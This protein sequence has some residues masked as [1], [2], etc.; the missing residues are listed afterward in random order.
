LKAQATGSNAVLPE[1]LNK[2]INF[3]DAERD[4]MIK[5]DYAYIIEN[6]SAMLEVWN[7][8]FKG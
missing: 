8:T 4:R 7:K 3:T 5:P 1:E 2:Q 6:Q